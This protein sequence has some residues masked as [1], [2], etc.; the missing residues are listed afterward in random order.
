MAKPFRLAWHFG[1]GSANLEILE[2]CRGLLHFKSG[3][4]IGWDSAALQHLHHL[5]HHQPFLHLVQQWSI[6]KL[7]QQMQQPIFVAQFAFSTLQ[8]IFEVQAYVIPFSHHLM[9]RLVES[10]WAEVPH[11]IQLVE[12]DAGFD[13]FVRLSV[14]TSS[15]DNCH[16]KELEQAFLPLLMLLVQCGLLVLRRVVY[17]HLRTLVGQER[18]FSHPLY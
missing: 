8:F 12:S 6:L 11:K 14:V 18:E 7:K 17:L 4:P 10:F 2:R 16:A 3:R 1:F 13:Y 5:S 15:F 9:E